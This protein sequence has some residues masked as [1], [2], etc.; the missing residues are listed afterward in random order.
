MAAQPSGTVTFLFTD[1]EGS[2]ALLQALGAEAY[3]S[4]LAEH[5]R[6]LRA[7][8]EG[9][10]GYEVDCEGDSFFVAFTDA[11]EA[12]AAAIEA[13]SSLDNHPW[14]ESEPI[15][16][17]MGIHT[18]EALL[19]PPKYVGIDV[20]RAARIMAA[21][22]GGQV[23]LSHAT[24][25]LLD[26][27]VELRNLGEHRL[28]DLLQPEQLYQLG[29]GTFPPLK[30]LYRSKLPIQPT[31]FL[32]R[33][34][35]LAEVVQLLGTSRLLTLTGTGGTGKTRLA[36]Q[37]GAEAADDYPAGVWWVSLG[38]LQDANLVMAAIA[39]ALEETADPA[40]AIGDRRL[41]LLLDNFEHVLDA[42]TDVAELLTKCPNL[43]VLITSRVPL[44]VRAEREYAVPP[45]VE[46][47][48][49]AFFL[50]RLRPAR[51]DFRDDGSVAQICRM[52]DHL[53]L[54]IEL[55]AARARTLPPAE[56]LGQLER[57]LAFLVDGY[58]DLPQRQRTL[59]ATIEWSY[60]LLD[61][62]A[63]QLFRRFSVFSGGSRLGAAEAVTGSSEEELAALVEQSLL[64]YVGDR[65]TMLETIREFGAEQLAESDE[66][67]DVRLRH[68]AWLQQF[69]KQARE[70]IDAHATIAELDAELPNI[71]SACAW[72]EQTNHGR[73]LMDLVA[74]IWIYLRLRSP[75]EA[76][77]LLEAAVKLS[78]EETAERAR[79]LNGLGGIVANE[80]DIERAE[81]L[82]RE[83]LALARK[84]GLTQVQRGALG[85]L[86][87]LMAM[88]GR[89][90]EARHFTQASLE[91]SEK[92]ADPEGI[93]DAWLGLGDIALHTGEF[94]R[95]EE[96]C[97]HALQYT[98]ATDAYALVALEQCSF[99]RLKQND[100]IGAAEIAAQALGILSELGPTHDLPYLLV[101]VA[102]A[103]VGVDPSGAA[104]MLGA[105]DT[106]ET[107]F[108]PV[109]GF[110]A[111]V[112]NETI[113]TLQTI[114]PE[115]WAEAWE[116][117]AKLTAE[118]T[119]SAAESLCASIGA[120]PAL[121]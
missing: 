55:A 79:A 78:S 13:Q 94:A 113:E 34:Q 102:A 39:Q 120:H 71:T 112:R 15:R 59:R 3:A 29:G 70:T 1:I 40:E 97:Q 62:E 43:R 45:L 47:E 30:S 121:S 54:A 61:P 72:L 5:R 52:L 6:L 76:R 107:T 21:G 17:R 86:G 28:K 60:R 109:A 11:A 105:V 68:A 58:R 104:L 92:T 96:C 106:L 18:G 50:E 27:S 119:I 116:R 10:N 81:L 48:A 80:G 2:T 89:L 42:A 33:K 88:R 91:L 85:N 22:H 12:V 51:P 4:A 7:A 65:Y 77:R 37:A 118:D 64:T 26:P 87:G 75:K 8:F 24:Q 53:P 57:R 73:E 23:V 19:D 67:D 16:V 99:A 44:H 69:A 83:S 93:R 31:A 36:L 56:I 35:E 115:H 84:V 38:P 63:Q 101:A 108:G 110:E 98:A 82:M 14:S 117:G 32:G 90:D 66:A 49:V 95:C 25:A 103:T 100:L 9:H 74:Y 46:E 41:L 20:H 111:S 114:A